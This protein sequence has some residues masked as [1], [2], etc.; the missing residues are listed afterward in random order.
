MLKVARTIADLNGTA[1]IQPRHMA[2]AIASR[3]LG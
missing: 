3:H 2:G 1:D